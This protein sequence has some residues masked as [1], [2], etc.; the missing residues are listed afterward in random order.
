MGIVS[1]KRDTYKENKGSGD[2]V[3]VIRDWFISKES[4]DAYRG[5]RRVI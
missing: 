5:I 4:N 3:I 2:M 1:N